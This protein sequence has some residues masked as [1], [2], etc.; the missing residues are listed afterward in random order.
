MPD[1]D[2]IKTMASVDDV[3]FN[4][5]SGSDFREVFNRVRAMYTG[6]DVVFAVELP[7]YVKSA[8]ALVKRVA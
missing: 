4:Y 8:I 2:I 5:A 1:L 3:F 7:V 6:N